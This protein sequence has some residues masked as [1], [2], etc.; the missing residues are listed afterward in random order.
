MKASKRKRAAT[1]RRRKP[2][3]AKPE[4]TVEERVFNVVASR[5]NCDISALSRETNF[6]CDL[7]ADSLDTAE[8]ATD[9]EDK[10][11]INSIPDEDMENIRTIGQAIEYV[12]KHT[13]QKHA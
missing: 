5:F 8:L 3:R 7:S 12:E 1:A 6:V 11:G 9:L 13:K 10:F 4:P 2:A